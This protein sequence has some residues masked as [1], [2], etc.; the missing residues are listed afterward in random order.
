MVHTHSI[1]ISYH[2]TPLTHPPIT[3]PTHHHTHIS[4]LLLVKVS[5]LGR[6]TMIKKQV[7]VQRVFSA[8]ISRSLFIIKGNQD[9][10][11]E[12]E[13]DAE[14]MV[15]TALWLTPHGLS[16]LLLIEP[17][18]ASPGMAPNALQKNSWKHFL[19]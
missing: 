12:A 6:D 2:H 3:T 15:G 11:P 19:N 5:L 17:K 16:S 7:G 1:T 18:S 13:A 9:R 4:P 14:A 8:Y 10:N